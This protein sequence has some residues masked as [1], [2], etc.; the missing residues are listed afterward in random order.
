[1][2]FKSVTLIQVM[3]GY[4]V[5]FLKQ[6]GHFHLMLNC[7]MDQLFVDTLITFYLRRSTLPANS[8]SDWMNMSDILTDDGQTQPAVLPDNTPLQPPLCRSTRISV[9]PQ[10]YG[11]DNTKT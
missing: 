4:L 3:A 5:P 10:R 11:Q 2:V 9:P 7:K 8:P 6:K 1:M